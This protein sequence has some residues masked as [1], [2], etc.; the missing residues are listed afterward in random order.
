MGVDG[1]TQRAITSLW[2]GDRRASTAI[3]A[4]IRKKHGG[5]VDRSQDST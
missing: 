2:N 1:W 3:A 5:P 4:I